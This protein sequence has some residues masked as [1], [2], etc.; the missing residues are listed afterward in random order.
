MKMINIDDKMKLQKY[1]T[2]YKSLK[3]KNV[4]RDIVTNSFVYL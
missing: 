1:F 4:H 2:F 3:I